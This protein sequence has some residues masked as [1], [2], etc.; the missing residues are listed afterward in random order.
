MMRVLSIIHHSWWGGPHNRNSRVAPLLRNRGIYTT[1]VVPDDEG[2]GAER[3][4][5]CGVEVLQMPLQRLR[6]SFNP[7]VHARHIARFAGDV[8]GLEKVIHEREIDVVQING[9]G[10]PQGAL[11]AKRQHIPVVWQILD[12]G[13]PMVVRRL[14]MAVVVRTGDALM[15][16]GMKVARAHPGAMSFGNRLLS[17]FPPVD[18]SVFMADPQVRN[19]ARLELGLSPEDSVIGTVGNINPQKDHM[20]FVRA[21]AELRRAYPKVRF[22]ILGATLPNRSQLAEQVWHCA[23]ELGFTLGRDL[24]VKNPGTRVSALEQAFDIFWLTSNS[25][26]MPTVV[27][28]AMA[29][30]LPVVSTE[31]GSIEEAIDNEHNGFIVPVRDIEAFVRVSIRLIENA[32]LSTQVAKQARRRAEEAFAAE[33]CADTHA[34]AF[35][36]A[37]ANVMGREQS[38]FAAASK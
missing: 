31:V 18:V 9:I 15:S 19:E 17:F 33:I 29:L 21:A 6:G 13:Y 10:N 37:I 23:R 30:G 32:E 11:A 26:G 20:T 36:I 14:A 12:T 2:D 25:E 3:L 4:R 35:E 34:R 8:R 38:K 28:E 7:S 5:A 27:E 16:T 22:V 24:I 1:V